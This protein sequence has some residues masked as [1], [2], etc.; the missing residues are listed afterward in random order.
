MSTLLVLGSKPQPR[1]PRPGGFDALACANASGR[2]AA[3]YGLGSAELTAMSAI[4]TSGHKEANHLALEALRGL[5]TGSLHFYPRHAPKGSPLRRAVH[6]ARNFRMKPWYF[7]RTLRA[8]GYQW[9]QFCNPGLDHC[10]RLFAE[11]SGNDPEVIAQMQLKQPSTGMLSLA[12]GIELGRWSR[13]VLAG[14]SFEITHDYAQNPL[15]GERGALSRHADTDVALLRAM[16][17]RVAGLCT[18]E[19][20]VHERTGLPL[21]PESSLLPADG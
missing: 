9:D 1:L 8:C 3:R 13:F 15:V 21:L 18:T 2:S 7:R 5:R 11:L 10:L 17:R 19:P 14:F 12:A 20:I 6:H 16:G 4:L